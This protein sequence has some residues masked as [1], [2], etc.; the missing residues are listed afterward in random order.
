MSIPPEIR[1]LNARAHA[2]Q[3]AWARRRLADRAAA[4]AGRDLAP[5]LRLDGDT[6]PVPAAMRA[7]VDRA[8]RRLDRDWPGTEPLARRGGGRWL[9]LM[10]P[11][12]EAAHVRRDHDRDG[13][14]D[15]DDPARLAQWRASWDGAAD[16]G[17]LELSV[18]YIGGELAAYCAAVLDWPAYRVLDSRMVTAW[19]RYSP[20]RVLEAAVI[21]R[22]RD[23]GEFTVL[24]WGAGGHEEALIAVT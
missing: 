10:R 5:F 8:R 24:D 18:L 23:S 12:I 3:L 20:G 11:V 6:D 17:R 16:A 2:A 4:G 22:L 19:R 14:S 13:W 7:Q 15:L 1:R 9:R 21:S